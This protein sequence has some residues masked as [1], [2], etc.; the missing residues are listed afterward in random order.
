MDDP[1]LEASRRRRA[2][3][4][5]RIEVEAMFLADLGPSTVRDKL[6]ADH[7]RLSSSG[8]PLAY[9]AAWRA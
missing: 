3:D 2:E 5:V 8:S 9:A 6:A 4:L 1:R 7:E